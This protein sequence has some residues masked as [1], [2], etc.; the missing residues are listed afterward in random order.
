MQVTK[1]RIER[2][3]AANDLAAVVA[4][5]GVALR[6]K[7][8]QLVAPC[9]FHKEKTAIL[10]RD[11]GEGALPLLR[12]RRIERRDRLRDEARQA[13][14]RRGARAAG[15]ACGA[16]SLEADGGAAARRRRTPLEALTPPRNGKLSPADATAE[17]APFHGAPP[18]PK[19]GE[20]LARVVEHY[21]RTFCEREDAQAYLVECR[22][23][24]TD[25]VQALEIGYADGSLLK[26]IPNEG[27]ARAPVIGLERPRLESRL[28][29]TILTPAEAR[30]IIEAPGT[31]SALATRDRAILETLYAT[32]I[33]A[34]ELIH[35]APSDVGRRRE[36]AAGRARQGRQGP[37]HSLDAARGRCD[38]QVLS[39]R[40][41]GAP[42]GDAHR[43]GCLP[44][45]GAG[46]VVR[47]PAGRDSPPGHSRQG[48]TS[49]G[50]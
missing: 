42:G 24:D 13:E 5:R 22:I 17:G 37:E 10:H 6:K 45:Q 8:K 20:I 46:S 3:K 14:L 9:P 43:P 2:I 33:R 32:G 19:A 41:A 1:D 31:R 27:A 26:L 30:R 21:H 16:R 15:P 49:L 25:L 50:R 38:S 34:S 23:T 29:R 7:G 48:R 47:L 39:A 12:L 18:Q 36:D 28:P 35:L 11:V 44:R 40:A 4:E